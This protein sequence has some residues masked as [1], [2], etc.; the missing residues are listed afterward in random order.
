MS[1]RLAVISVMLVG[2]LYVCADYVAAG[3]AQTNGSIVGRVTQISQ[4]DVPTIDFPAF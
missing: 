1:R 2:S 4:V 3:Q